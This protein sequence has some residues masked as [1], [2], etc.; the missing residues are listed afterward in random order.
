M[1]AR[2]LDAIRRTDSLFVLEE[3][4][5][6]GGAGQ[7][8]A[9]LLMEQ[10]VRPARFRHFHAEGYRSGRYGSQGYHRVENGLDPASVLASLSQD[11][12]LTLA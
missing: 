8:L 10:G 3:H 1:P 12:S 11:R 7:M 6:Q 5:A 2:L 4:V 9:H